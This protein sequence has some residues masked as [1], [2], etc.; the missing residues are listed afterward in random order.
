MPSDIQD[1]TARIRALDPEARAEV[2]R[3]LLADL[4][5]PAEPGVE[6]AWI[7]E[8]KRRQHE[9]LEGK[10]KPVPGEQVFANLRARLGG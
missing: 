6:Q 2:L 8:A 5:P 9:L 3:A 1:L 10:V 7:A 4:E